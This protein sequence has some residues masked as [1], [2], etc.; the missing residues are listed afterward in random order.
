MQCAGLACILIP[1]G[2]ALYVQASKRAPA[3][4]FLDELDGLVPARAHRAGS[5][6]Q[7]FASVVSTLLALMDGLH[8]R[9]KVVVI[10][11]TNRC[12]AVVSVLL[13]SGR[14]GTLFK[15]VETAFCA[16]RLATGADAAACVQ[17]PKRIQYNMA[18]WQ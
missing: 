17:V 8:D 16:R 2:S 6:D 5:Q 13:L 18:F 3:I 15:G 11:A 14:H 7:A 12:V 1:T 4:V 9:G 10:G